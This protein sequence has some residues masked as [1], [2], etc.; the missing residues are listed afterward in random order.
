MTS[1]L[2]GFA[3]VLSVAV[4]AVVVWLV[5][6][7]VRDDR[8]RDD[9]DLRPA[10]RTVA[11]GDARARPDAPAPTATPAPV[12]A[13]RADASIADEPIVVAPPVAPASVERPAPMVEV[14]NSDVGA[15]ERLITLH[16]AENAGSE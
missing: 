16:R 14:V 7:S 12:P 3:A 2:I 9:I 11:Y 6:V 1:T 8:R 10:P 13:E 4:W 5:A 15:W